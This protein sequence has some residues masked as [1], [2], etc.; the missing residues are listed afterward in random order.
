MP[1]ERGG[2]KQSRGADQERE[3]TD[4]KRWPE[5]A[6]DQPKHQEGGADPGEHGHRPASPAPSPIS[7]SNVHVATTFSPPP[8]EE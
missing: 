5:L 4:Q 1:T 3:A 8:Q 2:G 6:R 7:R